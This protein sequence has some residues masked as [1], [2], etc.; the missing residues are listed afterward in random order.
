M[1]YQNVPPHRKQLQKTNRY[2][3]E[4]FFSLF[5]CMIFI[6]GFFQGEAGLPGL[7]GLPGSK[8][9]CALIHRKA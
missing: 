2:L 7:D 6:R 1:I 5:L 9:G 4:V 3:F 8:V